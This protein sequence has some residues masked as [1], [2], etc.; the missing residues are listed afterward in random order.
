MRFLLT[1]LNSCNYDYCSEFA[2][3]LPC[4]LPLICVAKNLKMR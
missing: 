4:D 3:I 2:V 1:V